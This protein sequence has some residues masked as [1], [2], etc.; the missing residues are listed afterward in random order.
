MILAPASQFSEQIAVESTAPFYQ[1]TVIISPK[2]KTTPG[3]EE[4]MKAT[5]M[6]PSSKMISDNTPIQTNLTVS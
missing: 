6:S 3:Q 2:N 1:G 5:K 4:P